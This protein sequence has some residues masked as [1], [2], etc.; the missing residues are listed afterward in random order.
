MAVLWFG[1]EHRAVRYYAL[2]RPFIVSLIVSTASRAACMHA[3]VVRRND[4]KAP[5]IVGLL[6]ACSD[7]AG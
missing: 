4:T 3:W 1:C 7:R 5:Q 6:L 2:A